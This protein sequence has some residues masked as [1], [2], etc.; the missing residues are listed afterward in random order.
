MDPSTG[1]I[2]VRVISFKMGYMEYYHRTNKL[3]N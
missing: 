3:I 2:K 1:I